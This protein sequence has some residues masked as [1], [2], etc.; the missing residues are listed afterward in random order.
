MFGKNDEQFL[1]LEVVH[2]ATDL[3]R[4]LENQSAYALV[5]T[6]AVECETFVRECIGSGKVTASEADR[7]YAV[8]DAAVE[9]KVRA[10]N[11][12]IRRM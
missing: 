11:N 3:L 10:L 1:P 5:I 7:L 9:I 12:H 8:F 4:A 2:H 6:R